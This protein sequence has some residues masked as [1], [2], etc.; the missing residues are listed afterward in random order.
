MSFLDQAINSYLTKVKQGQKTGKALDKIKKLLEQKIKSVFEGEKEIPV[1]FGGQTKYW[2]LLEY[3]THTDNLNSLPELVKF[4]D[5]TL[6]T[7]YVTKNFMPAIM[8]LSERYL[9]KIR[10]RDISTIK[11]LLKE[12]ASEVKSYIKQGMGYELI[13]NTRLFKTEIQSVRA[14]SDISPKFGENT[15]DINLLHSDEQIYQDR[16]MYERTSEFTLEDLIDLKAKFERQRLAFFWLPGESFNKK[17]ISGEKSKI[18]MYIG[19]FYSFLRAN[20]FATYTEIAKECGDASVTGPSRDWL[21]HHL[22]EEPFKIDLTD[23]MTPVYFSKWTRDF[24]G[25]FD[26]KIRCYRKSCQ[27]NEYRLIKEKKQILWEIYQFLCNPDAVHDN[28][29]LSRKNIS[30]LVIANNCFRLELEIKSNIEIGIHTNKSL[31]H[32]ILINSISPN[33]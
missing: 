12:N 14:I 22:L 4:K 8:Y 16:T 29:N 7:A 19:F 1:N 27:N 30:S 33:L 25:L 20:S 24:L 15:D 3:I 13:N 26:R 18:P 10:K 28:V 5:R 2:F 31:Y 17:T 32:L 11:N 23:L 9:D 21:P 6:G